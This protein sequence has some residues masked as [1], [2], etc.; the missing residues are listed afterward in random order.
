MSSVLRENESPAVAPRPSTLSPMMPK[1]RANWPLPV[2]LK[3]M[4]HGYLFQQPLTIS[5]YSQG[6]N[7]GGELNFRIETSIFRVNKEISYDARAC[8]KRRRFMSLTVSDRST[9]ALLRQIIPSKL[10]TTGQKLSFSTPLEMVLNTRSDIY[11][12]GRFTL[13][14]DLRY[15][16]RLVDVLNGFKANQKENEV[17]TFDKMELKI[18]SPVDNF[19]RNDIIFKDAV[20]CLKNLRLGSN[21]PVSIDMKFDQK[22]L[23]T[24][25]P[26][27]LSIYRAPY[28]ER[29]SIT[30]SQNAREK[31]RAFFNKGDYATSRAYFL[32]AFNYLGTVPTPWA[33]RRFFIPFQCIVAGALLE[34]CLPEEKLGLA[35]WDNVFD[36]YKYFRKYQIPISFKAEQ[37]CV[38]LLYRLKRFDIGLVVL[39]CVWNQC[40]KS[41]EIKMDWIKNAFN[42]YVEALQ[43]GRNSCDDC[44][45]KNLGSYAPRLSQTFY[46]G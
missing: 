19:G 43:Q 6:E 15:L 18:N 21:L 34:S 10:I 22:T 3:N 12:L 25:Q 26:L 9:S 46:L 8:F 2:E 32:I 42:M 16:D 41:D 45:R 24:I 7:D 39:E 38:L 27:A 36:A 31:A 28:E 5:K 44:F 20:D 17:R 40:P 14:F 13:I 23:R 29:S 37:V 11:R 33:K 4:I 30:A 1:M 35:T